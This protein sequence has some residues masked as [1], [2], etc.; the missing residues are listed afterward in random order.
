[1]NDKYKMDVPWGK[2]LRTVEEEKLAD[3]LIKL[4]DYYFVTKKGYDEK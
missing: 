4:G 2:D 3:A 1:M